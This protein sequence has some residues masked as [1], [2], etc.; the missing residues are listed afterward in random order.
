MFLIRANDG[1]MNICTA[2]ASRALENFRSLRRA[3]LRPFI[4]NFRGRPVSIVALVRQVRV[5]R[6]IEKHAA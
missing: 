3:N 6:Y 5:Q 2:S 1:S 4:V